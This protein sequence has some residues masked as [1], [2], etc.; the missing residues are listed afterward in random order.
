MTQNI[1]EIVTFKL[2]SGVTIE[3]L[4]EKSAAF[5]EFAEKQKGFIYRSL[6][7]QANTDTFIDI[8]YWECMEDNQHM[9]RAFEEVEVCKAFCALVDK[10]SVGISHHGI[11]QQSECTA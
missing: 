7:Q 8:S 1:I 3:Q 10:E 9:Q 11:L 2:N 4:L 5:E 6:A